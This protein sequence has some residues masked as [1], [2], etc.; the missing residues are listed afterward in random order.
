M[1]V[2]TEEQWDRVM[3]A[4]AGQAGHAAGLLAGELPHEVEDV[5]AA[6]GVA[7]FPSRGGRLSTDC[8]CPDWANPCK[9]VA[10][11][12]YL[13][14]EAFDRDP[15]AVMAWRGRDRQAI[16]DRLRQLRSSEGES[17]GP[18]GTEELPLP[19]VPPL[20]E[21]LLGFWKAG[22]ELADVRIR[23][24]AAELPAALLRHL[25]RGLLHIRGRDVAEL[26]EPAYAELTAAAAR[27][28]M[29]SE[30]ATTAKPPHARRA[31]R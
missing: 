3:D 20:A 14:S 22:P 8:T 16:L 27:R 18:A 25:P 11:V 7:L 1:P 5:F 12:C 23:P 2:A 4:L 15:F 24:D 30:D 13:V 10:A 6:E 19:L 21:C 29:G 31:A 26:L 17:P 28:A 9:H